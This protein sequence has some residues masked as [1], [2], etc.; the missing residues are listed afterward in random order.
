MTETDIK[1]LAVFGAPTR[2]RLVMLHFNE[3][4]LADALWAMTEAGIE[5]LAFFKPLCKAS[6]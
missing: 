5:R 4:N 3:H 1:R 6:A 2:R